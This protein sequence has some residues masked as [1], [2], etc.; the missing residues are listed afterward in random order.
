MKNKIPKYSFKSSPSIEF[1]ITTF[2]KIYQKSKQKMVVPHRQ[3]F[4]GIF[5]YL[6]SKGSH[7]VDFKKHSIKKRNIFFISDEQVHHFNNVEVTK[8][9]VIFFTSSFLSHNNLVSRIFES[10][11][12]FPKLLLSSNLAK[13]IESVF[14]LINQEYNSENNYKKEIL[15]NYLNILLYEIHQ[16][17]EKKN[18]NYKTNIDY[19]RFLQFKNHLRKYSKENK[20]VKFYSDKQFITTKTL[21][22]SVRKIVDKSGK[23]FIDEYIIIC[24]KRLLVNS[25]ITV[26]E[27]AY[28][29]GFNEPT[30]FIK[31]FKRL[32]KKSPSKFRKSLF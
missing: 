6:N 12:N 22:L 26:K 18:I 5:Y 3:N 32:E 29:L 2:E 21:N 14:L 13:K 19:I 7:F 24:A 8:G 9:I 31:F 27:I 16:A 17:N 20:N 15:N 25:E 11:I 4:F 30:N 10:N 1:E 23:E 28:N